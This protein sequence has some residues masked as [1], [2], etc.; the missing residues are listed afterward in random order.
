[1]LLMDYFPPAAL[2][3]EINVDVYHGWHNFFEA[4]KDVS[5]HD[6]IMN[7]HKEIENMTN[8]LSDDNKESFDAA[9]NNFKSN[10][11]VGDLESVSDAGN[12][13]INALGSAAPSAHF[14]VNTLSSEFFGVS[15]P[16]YTIDIDFS[17]Y[18][19]YREQAHKII[20]AFMWISWA[21]LLYRRLPAIISGAPMD[22]FNN[23]DEVP[24]A[25]STEHVTFNDEG[26]VTRHSTVTK[27]PDGLVFTQVH[28]VGGKNKKK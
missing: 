12:S 15:I 27:N 24:E 22:I 4:F 16:S 6:Y 9:V 2:E 25:V 1:M 19:R 10:T 21:L 11:I 3:G 7:I 23:H 20:G 18:G 26:V 28:D 8:P 13:V 17:W 14:Y 5:L